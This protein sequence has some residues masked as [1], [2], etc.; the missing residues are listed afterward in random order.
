MKAKRRFAQK[1][2]FEILVELNTGKFSDVK[3]VVLGPTAAKISKINNN[4]RYRIALK[5][6]NSIKVRTM[7]TEILKNMAKIK[8]YKTVTVSIDIN[9]NE[10]S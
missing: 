7:I 4:Y 9:P 8:E 1:S 3:L 5:C 6:K 2:F 10:I